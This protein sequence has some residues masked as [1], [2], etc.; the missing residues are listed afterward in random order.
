MRLSPLPS[1]P[2]PEPEGFM[3]QSAAAKFGVATDCH[4]LTTVDCFRR[5]N[6]ESLAYF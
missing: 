2:E 5:K 1:E 4:P 3:L 6:H